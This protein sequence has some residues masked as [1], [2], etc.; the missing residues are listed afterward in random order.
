MLK[1]KNNVL[2]TITKQHCGEREI[3]FYEE[4]E[5]T[6]DPILIELKDFVPKYYGTRTVPI[7]G[8]DVKCIELED[9]TRNYKEPCIMDIKI[10]RRTWDPTASYEK[11]INEDV[12]DLFFGR[13]FLG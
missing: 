5:Q 1:H 12:I 7:N 11:I 3:A 4:L 9:L 6:K 10:G 2:K 13:C 8:K